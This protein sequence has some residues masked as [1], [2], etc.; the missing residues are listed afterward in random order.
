MLSHKALLLG[1]SRRPALRRMVTGKPD[2]RRVV[3]RFAAGE[4]V[5]DALRSLVP[6]S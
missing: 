2:T 4:T 3:D 5:Q 6:R 1:A